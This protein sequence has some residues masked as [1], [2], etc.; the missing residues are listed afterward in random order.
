M[1]ADLARS[2]LSVNA[3]MPASLKVELMRNHPEWSHDTPEVL[4]AAVVDVQLAVASHF[5]V[6][7]HLSIAGG[8]RLQPCHMS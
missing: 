5:D 1:I 8:V 4:A 7:V 2:I 3:S 6:P